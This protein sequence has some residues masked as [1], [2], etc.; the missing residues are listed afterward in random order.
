MASRPRRPHRY[1]TRTPGVP[2]TSTLITA[3]PIAQNELRVDRVRLP[4]HP[5]SAT[6]I[7]K[8]NEG[9]LEAGPEP[10]IGRRLP[11]SSIWIASKPGKRIC[12]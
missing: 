12:P 9:Q 6:R 10:D 11:S 2:S 3:Q 4:L 8:P 5:G 1:R 7:L